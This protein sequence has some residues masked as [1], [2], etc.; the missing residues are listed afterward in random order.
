MQTVEKIALL[1]VRMAEQGLDALIVPSTDPHQSEYV[2]AHWQTR[3][4]LSGFIG[5]AGTLVLTKD[6]AGLWTD[7]R[8]F[9]QAEQQLAGSGIALFKMGLPETPAH[10]AWLASELAAGTVVGIDPA[11]F[12]INA[13]RAL[14]KA[15]AAKGIA[16]RSVG[17]LAGSLWTDRPPLPA[18]RAILHDE[19]IAGEGR[20]S[21]LSRLRAKL[22]EKNADWHIIS[23]LDDIAWLY[24]IRGSDVTCNPVV[25]AYA[26]VS[27]DEA[28]LFTD[29]AKFDAKARK[30]LAADGVTLKKYDYLERLLKKIRKQ[31]ILI[32]PDRNGRHILDTLGKKAGIVEGP[33]IPLLLKAVKNETEIAGMRMAHL[34]DG[35]AMV[36]FLAWLDMA[37]SAMRVTEISAAVQI[38]E[39]R[40]RGERYV[41]P[42]FAPIV[43]YGAHGAIV[44]YS[45]TPE[46]DAE[47]QREGLLLIDSGGQYL[48]GTTDITRT[49]AVGTPTDGMK[50]HFT[51]VLKGHIGVASAVFPAG[52]AGMFLDPF[53]RRALW[54]DRLNYGHGTGH[55]VGA[56]LSVHEGPQGISPRVNE[57][58][59]EPGMILSNE[60]GYYREGAYGIRTENLVLVKSVGENEGANW[61]GFETITLCPIDLDLVDPAILS[62]GERQW[63][64]DYHRTV[65]ESLLPFL[66][67]EEKE[68]LTRETREI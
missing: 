34:R 67:D 16:L 25:I 44:H 13:F 52:T 11:L 49:I 58:R 57:T 29:T 30:A 54:D 40:R 33:A 5:S 45:A 26:A 28:F 3:A 19:D 12:S 60:P 48:D 2:A 51:L 42:S 56:Y 15:M 23:T 59:L 43:G 1:R 46:T 10:T 62:P 31:R 35:V 41:G 53:A 50:R 36:R 66:T 55:G 4:W 27:R 39:I 18:D 64:N 63:L 65:R 24:N 9:L 6:K 17:D 37:L 14:E 61:L 38:E 7:S 20:T 21:K 47:I 8:Y 68:W 22:A 32:D